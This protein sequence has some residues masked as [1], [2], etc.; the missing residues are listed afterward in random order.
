MRG[1]LAGLVLVLAGCAGQ[2]PMLPPQSDR[3]PERV[4]LSQTPFYPQEIYQCGP[5][6]LATL[7]VQRG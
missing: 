1:W 4:E 3:L 5:A 7:L 2:Q 6:A